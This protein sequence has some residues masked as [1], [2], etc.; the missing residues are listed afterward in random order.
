MC[1]VSFI[2]VGLPILLIFCRVSTTVGMMPQR[3]T[4]RSKHKISPMLSL[5]PIIRS[6]TKTKLAA[7]HPQVSLLGF[8]LLLCWPALR[9]RR[10]PQWPLPQEANW[11]TRPRR[12]VSIARLVFASATSRA[13]LL[14]C[15]VVVACGEVSW[16]V[17]AATV[18]GA[19]FLL[20]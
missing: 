19:G 1:S 6:R 11:L 16:L 12:A 13:A 18:V 9:L 2:N 3:Q 4:I 8:V 20:V 14:G 10:Q 5:S 17:L 7:M 15:C